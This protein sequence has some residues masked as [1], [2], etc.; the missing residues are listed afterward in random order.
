MLFHPNTWPLVRP[1]QWHLM[2]IFLDVVATAH[3]R[4]NQIEGE[5]ASFKSP[6][7][8]NS[9][10]WHL[11]RVRVWNVCLFTE[12]S[13]QLSDCY[14]APVLQIKNRS[15][16]KLCTKEFKILCWDQRAQGF[17]GWRNK[18]LQG[19]W[20]TCT[21]TAGRLC[22]HSI[23]KFCL[24]PGLFLPLNMLVSVDVSARSP[25]FEAYIFAAGG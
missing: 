19:T 15:W 18:L 21:K 14:I 8:R 20:A 25:F 1:F 10:V 4:K 2:S 11:S 22:S 16:E 12:A 7:F 3:V 23:G 5:K 24:W 9:Q 13:E 6:R 17:Q